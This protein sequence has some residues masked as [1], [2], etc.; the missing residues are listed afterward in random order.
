MLLRTS[1]LLGVLQFV[2]P[3]DTSGPARGCFWCDR[4]QTV[5]RFGFWCLFWGPAFFLHSV[6]QGSGGLALILLRRGDPA[7]RGGAGWKKK[8]KKAQFGVVCRSGSVGLRKKKEAVEE[9]EEAVAIRRFACRR[10]FEGSATKG[11]SSHPCAS[12]LVRCCV[13]ARDGRK[14][15]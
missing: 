13:A 9:A 15:D 7:S 2:C 10:C 8:K 12:L 14:Q 4:R 11:D 3:D 6:T 1:Y 5:G